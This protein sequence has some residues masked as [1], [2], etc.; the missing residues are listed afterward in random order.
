MPD[1]PRITELQNEYSDVLTQWEE[2]FLDSIENWEGALTTG[3]E[4]KLQQI[5][6]EAPNRRH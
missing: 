3:Q 6:E 1:D 4:V 2:E 5:Y